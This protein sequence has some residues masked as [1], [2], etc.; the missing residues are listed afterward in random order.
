MQQVRQFMRRHTLVVAITLAALAHT[1]VRADEANPANALTFETHV[2]PILAKHCRK[3]HSGDRPRGELDLSSFANLMQ[4]GISGKVVVAGKPDESLL[5]TLSAHLE[6]PKMPPNSPKIPQTELDTLRQWIEGGLQERSRSTT[7]ALPNPAPKTLEGLQ[8]AALLPRP[9]PI[10]ALA[11]SPTGP[12]VAISGNKQV[13][14]YE[15]PSAKLLGAVAF[16]EG[17]VHS[18]RFSPDAKVLLA[19]GG[20]GGQSG[21]IAGIEVGTWK[22]LFTL[23]DATDAILCADL[24]SDKT[25][26]AFGG[27]SRLV[28]IAAVADGQILHTFRKPTDWVMSVAFSPEGLLLAAGDRFGGLY[29]WEA[30]SGKEF[31]TL[32]GHTKAVMAIA[33]QADSNGFVSGS[34]DGSV[35]LWDMHRLRETAQ[36]TAHA[37]GV[38]DVVMHADGTLATA[39]RDHRVRVWNTPGKL[40]AELGP[41]EDIAMRVALSADGKTVVAGDWAGTVQLWPTGGGK[42]TRFTLPIDPKPTRSATVPVPV[43]NLPVATVRPTP[44][45]AIP[46]A[47]DTLKNDLARKLLVLR[48]I[49]DAVEKLKDEAARH[50]KN[51]ALAKA[52]LQLC[53]AA[54]AMKADVLE[55]QKA[56][57]AASKD[58]K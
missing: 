10:T 30:K 51:E 24:S 48:T 19:A 39:G 54:L 17:E 57:E 3:C 38:L 33:W 25:R 22:R 6:D 29:V 28:K 4:G 40:L 27:P 44:P 53:E 50:P 13:L 56:I 55:T 42:G 2:K 46:T 26:V 45:T 47:L 9:T 15:L 31:A 7:V 52:Y 14:L 5:Y 35:R 41:T 8:K 49:E 12:L 23:T 18:L 37:D 1:A 16:P 32:R 20:V 58:S 11:V 43:P 34:E 36:W 21:A